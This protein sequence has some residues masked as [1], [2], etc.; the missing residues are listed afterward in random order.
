VNFLL[1]VQ[2]NIENIIS[3][4][5]SDH[6]RSILN[7][8]PS[9][10][11]TFAD[12][13]ERAT[14]EIALPESNSGKFV[15]AL[16][17]ENLDKIDEYLSKI[18]LDSFIAS[19]DLNEIAWMYVYSPI[20]P[21]FIQVV[22]D[23]IELARVSTMGELLEHRDTDNVFF[24]NFTTNQLF[25]LK[26]IVKLL[27]D[28]EE[29]DPIVVQNINSFD[30]FGLM[31]GLQ[32]LYLENNLN[33]SKRIL[34]VNQNP[35]SINEEGFKLTLRRELDIWRVLGSTP[36]SNYVGATPE[37]IE[38]ADMELM[39]K[40]FTKEGIPTRDFYDFVEFVNTTFPTNY[41]YIKWGESYWD[42]AGKNNEGVFSLP[43]I[44]DAATPES[45][46]DIFQPGI[47]DFEDARI[48][49]DKVDQE[50]NQYSFGLRVRG[51][52]YDGFENAYEPISIKY[53]SYLS[54]LEQYTDN[55][56]AT[57]DY[58]VILKLN[59]HGNIPND[60]VYKARYKVITKNQYDISA[61]PEFVVKPVFNPTGF[62]NGESTFYDESGTPYLNIIDVSATESYTFTQIPLFAVDEAT[63]SF[64]SSKNE[65]G[66]NGNYGAVGFLDATP[67]AVAS[68]TNPVVVK[69][70]AQINDSAYAMNLRVGSRIYSDKKIREVN[71][72]K[73]RSNYFGNVLNNSSNIEQ[74]SPIIFTPQDVIKNIVVPNGAIPQYIHI[75]NV[76]VDSY[77]ID[78]STAPY[79]GYGGISLN[80]ETG[81]LHLIPSSPNIIFS[82][83]NP[84][85]ATPEQMPNY[86][87]TVS[88]TANYYFADLKFPYDATPDYFVISSA[89]SSIYPFNTRTWEKFT[90]DLTANK[91]FYIGPNGVIQDY[92]T[93]NYDLIDSLD[94]NLV[95]RFD[96]S[97]NE[98]GLSAYANSK[99][100][101]I[102]DIEV[103]NENDD[104]D[105]YA[106]SRPTSIYAATEGE[107]ES[108]IYDNSFMD[109]A[110]WATLLQRNQATPEGILNFFD[111]ERNEF[112]VKNLP[113]Y[114]HKRDYRNRNIIPSINT[115]WYY[116]NGQERYIYAKPVTESS[117]SNVSSFV[118]E[119]IARQ[120]A[121]LIVN[122]E[123]N[124][125]G[126]T[127][128]YTQVSFFDE[129]TP[130]VFSYHNY[131]YVTPKHQNY[132][133]LS[134]GNV[135]DTSVFDTFTGETIISGSSY[136]TNVI[137]LTSSA[138]PIIIPNR[139]YKVRY[140]VKD[141]FYVDNEHYVD[142]DKSYRT[143]ITL[144]ST[145]NYNWHV[146]A[147]YESA[148][149]DSDYEIDEMVLNPL[150]SPMDHGFI[151]LSHNEYDLA[152]L[153]ASL[154][155]KTILQGTND[156]MA[157][158]VW[159]L[160]EN[161]N[162][163]PYRTVNIQGSDSVA[164]PSFVVTNEE[165]YARAYVKYS[166]PA[167]KVPYIHYVYVSDSVEDISATVSYK[168]IPKP[169]DP[170]KLSAD[171]TKKILNADG[172][173][174]LYV[175]GNATPNVRIYWR[176]GRTL[177]GALQEQYAQTNSYGV[178]PG[179][180]IEATSLLNSA[181]AVS[182][183]Q[184][185]DFEIGPFLAQDDATPGYWFVAVDSELKQSSSQNPVTISGDIVYWYERYDVNQSNSEEPV[186]QNVSDDATSYYHY[187]EIPVIK[188]SQITNEVYYEESATNSWN[189]P[190]WYPI[191]RL[192]QYR[193]GMLGS[194]P[195]V[196]DSYDNLRPDYE[197]E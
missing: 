110:R 187:T 117:D 88:S 42:Y 39:S 114:A 166:G 105:I 123:N 156:F 157:L 66:S 162:P 1:L 40:Y 17:G 51:L 122:I 121:P 18:E 13:L 118:L 128:N 197:E 64:V 161:K 183:D 46:L 35:P 58:D 80:R 45:Y 195:Y 48:K 32:R 86:I 26:Q 30:Q 61:S 185:G 78:H 193:T 55:E 49:L 97:R 31:V 76:I 124:S 22:G 131:E 21:G 63:I 158:N 178:R 44:A 192:D 116:Q 34:D 106:V 38:I 177:Y 184:N 94:G 25:I 112:L 69:T 19:A 186:L 133:P 167:T 2:I 41:G 59:L 149:F 57:I 168:S 145:P 60:S 109:Q 33:F 171:V 5:I 23:S 141:S 74:Q 15:N 93:V 87:D 101:W 70:A 190:K 151:Y 119:G 90:A 147:V 108:E 188:K 72:P 92:S 180:Q 67:F 96:L 98:F 159:S 73:I 160:D 11:K 10:S 104:V 91:D 100:L 175:Y 6:A 174:Y 115:G 12:S 125:T 8:F 170:Q 24:Y 47:G 9:W 172:K 182:A 126:A 103:I 146:N 137:D 85:F 27:V 189:L 155:P 132:I 62:T 81:D 139:Q 140:R 36:D 28:G 135:F 173:E 83:V 3:P 154:S 20:Q 52:K 29:Y 37:L 65:S 138:T 82:Y 191:S 14:P 129:A 153:E 79:A 181:G 77:D 194:T 84:N 56:T 54:Y 127:S 143:K 142:T 43:Q 71:T 7:R 169:V 130:T 164:T 99:N 53:D 163:K 68:S 165:G 4:V 95:G 120:G 102:S 179:S 176:K 196:I 152:A 50:I 113:I 148:I 89:D 136:P 107:T 134:Y 150:L 75:E 111:Q 16:I 144:L